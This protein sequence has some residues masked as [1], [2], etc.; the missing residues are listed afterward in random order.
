[1]PGR[2]PVAGSPWWR[3]LRTPGTRASPAA[4]GT[5]P[6]TG[7][8]PAPRRSRFLLFR[9]RARRRAH[10][11]APRD[12]AY[13]GPSPPAASWPAGRRSA[14]A[15]RPPRGPP[16][17]AGS[18]GPDGWPP[19]GTAHPPG[20]RAG[21]SPAAPATAPRPPG[22]ALLPWSRRGSG[23]TTRRVPRSPRWW[24]GRAAAPTGSP[25]TPPPR[26]PP[27]PGPRPGLL[28][29]HPRS[30]SC[31]GWPGTPAGI[32]LR[33]A[34]PAVSPRRGRCRGRGQPGIAGNPPDTSGH[35]PGPARSARTPPAPPPSAA[36]PR[37]PAPDPPHRRRLVPD[38]QP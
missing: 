36:H 7:P 31:P 19:T 8:D 34:A 28:P 10:R 11:N 35:P 1:M 32:A 3:G 25:P 30:A 13:P 21:R 14:G 26:W 23:R 27:P 9:R 22:P 24:P 37:L 4:A 2:P 20:R 5:A 38:R 12:T 29:W 6:R 15:A 17:P 16:A 18:G 33:R